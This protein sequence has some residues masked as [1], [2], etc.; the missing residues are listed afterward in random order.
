ME[1]QTHTAV[2]RQAKTESVKSAVPNTMQFLIATLA[3]FIAFSSAA[4]QEGK[5]VYQKDS[6]GNTLY[7]KQ[8]WVIVKGQMCP[9]DT[10]GSRQYHKPCLDIG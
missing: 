7:H 8:S 2:H 9:V 1:Y 6:T 5:R 10:V 4:Q 3:L